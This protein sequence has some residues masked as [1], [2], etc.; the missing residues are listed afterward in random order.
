[1]VVSEMITIDNLS[2]S[3]KQTVIF[4]QFNLIISRGSFTTIAGP[5]SSGK[6][7]LLRILIGLEEYQG[8]IEI[9]DLVLSE[10]AKKS[11]RSKTGIVFEN[12]DL[13][14]V[15]ETVE[16]ELL[17]PMENANYS[18]NVMKKRV[19]ELLDLFSLKELKNCSIHQLS[20]G[21]KQL[22]A[23]ASAL[24]LEP[25]LLLLDEAFS[26]ID[27]I[28]K[29]KCLRILKKL[30]KEKKLTIVQ[31]THDLEESIYGTDLVLIKD[32]KLLASGKVMDLL[33]DEKL[34]KKSALESPF[35]VQLSQK[36]MYYDLI[37]EPILDM[38]RMVN[39][40]WK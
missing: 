30:N 9:D 29:E 17:F 23:I 24:A 5:N 3:I 13:N 1:M 31:V 28:S 14:F 21:E 22:V 35:M 19:D 40:L 34:I 2:C 11:I 16:D 38:N 20:G 36:L 12:P 25:T 18:R 8:T 7:T 10:A 15:T 26:M 4:D 39:T 27:G 32:G 6:S 33:T 37:K